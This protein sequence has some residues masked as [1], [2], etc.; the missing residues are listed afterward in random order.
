MP[1]LSTLASCKLV[2]FSGVQFYA[3]TFDRDT[4]GPFN[5]NFYV[6]RQRV[7][8]GGTEEVRLSLKPDW[9]DDNPSAQVEAPPEYEYESVS[10]LK[11]YEAFVGEWMP[12]PVLKVLGESAR[13]TRFGIGHTNWARVLVTP[14]DP[15]ATAREA[16]KFNIVYAF[17][18]QV[19][20]N[21]VDETIYTSPT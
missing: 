6:V 17:D 7:R 5:K 10:K 9:D 8:E 15:R 4:G 18:T 11:S 2:P 21:P 14:Q 16:A 1:D 13:G 19:A 3:T 20:E 12:V